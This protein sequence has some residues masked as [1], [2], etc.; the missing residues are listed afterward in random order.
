MIYQFKFDVIP[1]WMHQLQWSKM[2]FKDTMH[3]FQMMQESLNSVQWNKRYN[4]FEFIWYE[5]YF[6][7]NFKK[8]GLNRMPHVIYIYCIQNLVLYTVKN[9]AAAKNNT[10]K[11]DQNLA[12]NRKHTIYQTCV[13][14]D[15]FNNFDC[16]S[17]MCDFM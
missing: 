17:I 2:K 12:T 8:Y 1:R 3:I 6:D 7:F 15:L 13:I 5:Y 10:Q 9:K 16:I 11:N 14:L 4:R